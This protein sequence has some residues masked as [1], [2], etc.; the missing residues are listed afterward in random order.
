MPVAAHSRGA[1]SLGRD[2]TWQPRANV[3]RRGLGVAGV[4]N[5]AWTKGCHILPKVE[6]NGFVMSMTF[7]VTASNSSFLHYNNATLPCKS[8][9]LL[10]S[11]LQALKP[12]EEWHA[13]KPAA[14]AKGPRGATSGGARNS[15]ERCC[16]RAGVP[17]A[18][19]W[20]VVTT[21]AGLRFWRIKATCKVELSKQCNLHD[22]ARAVVAETEVW[23]V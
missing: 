18:E 11:K 4:P 12:V 3:I 22:S 23:I 2:A 16:S 1:N 7:M 19:H 17:T 8:F 5:L 6:D 13:L 14:M 9:D 21:L 20:S 10:D 15:C